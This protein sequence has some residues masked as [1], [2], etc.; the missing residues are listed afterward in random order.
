MFYIRRVI[1]IYQHRIYLFSFLNWN[2]TYLHAYFIKSIVGHISIY[3]SNANKKNWYLEEEKKTK[4]TSNPNNIQMF[5]FC[6]HIVR[7]PQYIKRIQ[8]SRQQILWSQFIF[9]TF[10]SG[11]MN[12]MHKQIYHN[13]Y[14]NQESYTMPYLPIP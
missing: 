11:R 4:H 12:N 9:T 6:L 7:S 3:F 10:H 8:N 14:A 1:C 2:I 13:W 5:F